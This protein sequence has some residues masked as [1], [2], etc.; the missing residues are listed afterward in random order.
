V[1]GVI[2]SGMI[3]PGLIKSICEDASE[4]IMDVYEK[5]YTVTFKD[6]NSPFTAADQESNE[7]IMRLLKKH[8]P[9]I[10][11]ISEEMVKQVDYETRKNWSKFWLVDPLDGSKEFIKKNDQFCVIISLI[12]HNEPV[13]GMM[14]SPVSKETYYAIK[15]QGAYKIVGERNSSLPLEKS[16]KGQ[17]NIIGSLSHSSPE[18]DDFIKQQESTGKKTHV[19]QIGSGLKFCHVAE[20][21]AD[22]YP[23]FVPTME[24]DTAAGQLLVEECGKKMID[25]QTQKRMTYNKVSLKNNGFI[26][27]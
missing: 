6:D 13:F 12:E 3:N 21:K 14:Y 10:P 18:F 16:P 17:V 27:S 15:G 26:V 7:I 4:A 25:N 23:R 19:V 22:I 1:I 8:Y 20:G 2:L 11:I 24:W 9:E 5:D